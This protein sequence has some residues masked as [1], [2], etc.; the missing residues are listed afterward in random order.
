MDRELTEN[1]KALIERA[2]DAPYSDWYLIY[3]WV[4]LADTEEAKFTLRRISSYKRHR[5]EY[6]DI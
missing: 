2:Y 1:D 3:D 5:E 6:P 4:E